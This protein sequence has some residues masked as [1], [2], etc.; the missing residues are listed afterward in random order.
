MKRQVEFLTP[1]WDASPSQGYPSALNS[2]V[3]IYT[4]G[5]R[6]GRGILRVKCLA[7]E[8]HTMPLA[9]AQT[10][11]VCPR[12]ERTNYEAAAPPRGVMGGRSEIRP[13]HTTWEMGILE[14][15][16]PIESIEGT[17]RR[18]IKNDRYLAISSVSAYKG[19]P[20]LLVTCTSASVLH[21]CG[22]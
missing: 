18:T 17:Y 14:L 9:R 19:K 20:Q 6:E 5:W 15:K 21:M 7:Q 3:S 1:G 12:V 10:R 16:S 2:P 11:A 13:T 8:H 4:P 22:F